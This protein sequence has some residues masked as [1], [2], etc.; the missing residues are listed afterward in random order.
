MGIKSI[1]L[2][3]YVE[4]DDET[5]Y[6]KILLEITFQVK[7]GKFCGNMVV[8]YL[9]MV[10]THDWG[11]WRIRPKLPECDVPLLKDKGEY[12]IDKDT[13]RRLMTLI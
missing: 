1:V 8:K 5:F 9:S 7:N 2:Y 3:V 12:W 11:S 4:L 6:I 10:T 13:Y